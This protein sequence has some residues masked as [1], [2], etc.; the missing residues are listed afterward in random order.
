MLKL[1]R[2]WRDDAAVHQPQQK[3]ERAMFGGQR[4]GEAFV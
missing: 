1:D 3:E 2:P 4:E